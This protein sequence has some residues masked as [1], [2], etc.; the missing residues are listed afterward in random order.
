VLGYEVEI[1]KGEARSARV[2]NTAQRLATAACQ[3]EIDMERDV[4]GSRRAAAA[5]AELSKY[6]RPYLLV[7]EEPGSVLQVVP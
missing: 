7:E 1:I 3:P 4:W 6:G 2:V 5:D